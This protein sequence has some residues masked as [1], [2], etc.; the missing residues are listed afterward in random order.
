[1]AQMI[2]GKLSVWKDKKGFGFIQPEEGGDDVFIHITALEQLSRRPYI[3]DIVFYELEVEQDGRFKA[4]NAYIEGV[5]QTRASKADG[6]KGRTFAKWF[7]TL[8]ILIL[9]AVIIF[10]VYDSRMN[11]GAV[12]DAIIGFI[13]NSNGSLE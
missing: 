10:Y 7:F 8:L 11:E 3:G 9:V 5:S 13:K 1:M 2:K 12:M 4:V 6:S